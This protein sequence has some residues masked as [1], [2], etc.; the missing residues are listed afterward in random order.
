MV[1]Y[2]I[3]IQSLILSC[4][5]YQPPTTPAKLPPTSDK[6]TDE[7]P[8]TYHD[9]RESIE[10][11][12]DFFQNIWQ[13]HY[14]PGKYRRLLVRAEQNTS[15]SSLNE[16]VIV[17][18]TLS[19][20]DK[21]AHAPPAT[22]SSDPEITETLPKMASL[23][24]AILN[25]NINLPTA[26]RENPHLNSIKVFK[27]IR[28]VL[29]KTR[30]SPEFIQEI[31]GFF[32]EESTNFDQLTNFIKEK[33]H[34]SKSG[35]EED[36]YRDS[37]SE[38]VLGKPSL[39]TADLLISDSILA[40]AD[41]LAENE[42]YRTAIKVAEKI[43]ESNPIYGAAQQKVKDFSNL[44]VRKLRQEAAQAF[45]NAIPVS[46]TATKKSYLELAKGF[47]E[48]AIT[49]YPHADNLTTVKENLAVITRNLY[50]LENP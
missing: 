45:Q 44:A 8:L 39:S 23:E 42:E 41:S 24:I 47:L 48:Q 16:A 22:F 7:N 2:L 43:T 35:W 15:Q 14:I 29:T 5:T 38:N 4:V 6:V 46:D 11:Y 12:D 13:E 18:E 21:A 50:R 3:L 34:D 26:L 31:Q 19:R 28:R 9:Q 25:K 49:D 1:I 37:G 20:L 27:L 17:L 40:K 10:E 30:N 32:E 36:Q 33:H